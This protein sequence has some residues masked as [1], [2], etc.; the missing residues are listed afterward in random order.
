M[1]LYNI[2]YKILLFKLLIPKYSIYIVQTDDNILH[3]IKDQNVIE[4]NLLKINANDYISNVVTNY[5]CYDILPSLK[6]K[7]DNVKVLKNGMIYFMNKKF[8]IE[9]LIEKPKLISGIIFQTQKKYTTIIEHGVIIFLVSLHLN[10]IDSMSLYTRYELFLYIYYPFESNENI[11]V[12]DNIFIHENKSYNFSSRIVAVYDTVI[13]DTGIY[14]RRI[15]DNF[16][17]QEYRPFIHKTKSLKKYIFSFIFLMLISMFFYRSKKIKIIYKEYE[18][19]EYTIS[20]GIYN[21]MPVLIKKYKE[22]NIK[23]ID[24]ITKLDLIGIPKILYFDSKFY[25]TFSIFEY[26]DRVTYLTKNELKQYTDLI[27]FLIEQKIY[28]KN[29]NPINIRRKN[30]QIKL[31]N[32]FDNDWF[33]WYPNNLDCSIQIKMVMSVGIIIHY[34]LTGYH[35]FDI[36]KSPMNFIFLKNKN[37]IQNIKVENILKLKKYTNADTLVLD[38]NMTTQKYLIRLSDPLRH[39]LIYHTIKQRTTIKKLSK[40]PYFWSHERIFLF[41]ANYSDVLEGSISACKKLERNKSRIF[42]SSWN[43]PLDTLIKDELSIFRNYN[44][45]NAKDLVRVIRNS[46]RHYNQIPEVLKEFYGQFP[47]G[48][49]NYWTKLFPGLLIVC[50]NCGES[51]KDNELLSDYY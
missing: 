38:E 9:S 41:L 11:V 32:L 22:S 24:I 4:L 21:N 43:T 19:K 23:E 15:F 14:M 2:F 20:K 27:L 18:T 36:N 12:N 51:L 29:F 31:V 10:I 49:V 3:F 30:N 16:T 17:L 13:Y 35:P 28:F 50:Y 44:Y 39:D 40:H 46:G 47:V 42:D 26:S 25:R 1:Y 34:F 33:G 45:N 48:F 5:E 8:S 7:I 6:Y 37:L